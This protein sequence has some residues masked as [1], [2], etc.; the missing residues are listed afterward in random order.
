MIYLADKII[1]PLDSAAY[2][3]KSRKYLKEGKDEEALHSIE[4]AYELNKDIQINLYY[5]LM[6]SQLERYEE[7]LDIMSKEKHFYTNNESHALFY[8]KVLIKV[9]R[10]IE[11]EYIIQK[12]KN[13][14]A[15]IHERA[16]NYSEQDLIEEREK[17]NIELSVRR[18]NIKRSLRELEQ[19]SHMVQ[20]RKAKDAQILD[21]PE[22]QEVAPVILISSAISETVQR[23]FLELLIQKDD[24]NIY[25]FQWFNQIKKVCPAELPK[26]SEIELV[27]EI[28]KMIEEKLVKYPD[29]EIRVKIEMMHDLLLLYPFID[30]TITD[31]DFW[32]DAYI[33]TLDFFNYVKIKPMIITEEQQEMMKWIDYLNTIA[34]RNQMFSD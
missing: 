8:T 13:D 10:F 18:E 30:E 1:F 28:S 9:Q 20:V 5:V 29:L 27:D 26:F 34:Q 21:L 23:S 17:T 19:Y 4:K 25:S 16:W 31:V 24:Q 32:V 12:Y 14:P 3:R 15:T 33:N 22:L 2:L 7:A 6:L 11:A